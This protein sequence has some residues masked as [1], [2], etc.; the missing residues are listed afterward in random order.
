MDDNV[1]RTKPILDYLTQIILGVWLGDGALKCVLFC[2]S[3]ISGCKWCEREQVSLVHMLT[4]N[5]MFGAWQQ[6]SMSWSAGCT[7]LL[8]TVT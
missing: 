4:D 6:H 1:K 5:S 3:F 2:G 8:A 7:S